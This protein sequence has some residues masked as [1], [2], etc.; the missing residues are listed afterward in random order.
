MSA[1]T[2]EDC[3][4]AGSERKR[5][6]PGWNG[7]GCEVCRGREDER[8][9]NIH[10]CCDSVDQPKGTKKITWSSLLVDIASPGH[11]ALHQRLTM[12]PP[13]RTHLVLAITTSLFAFLLLSLLLVITTDS[14]KGVAS[15]NVAQ[16]DELSRMKRQELAGLDD[17][18]SETS[19][20]GGGLTET[21]DGNSRKTKNDR[22]LIFTSD[23]RAPVVYD[24][25]KRELD[26]WTLTAL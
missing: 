1:G 2:N 10:D 17:D 3:D 23:S 7:V 4:F 6:K 26:V 16:H 22:V 18:L 20:Y 5:H 19:I 15:A 21:S 8:R 14:I 11:L 24:D 25:P 12:I 13:R 9:W